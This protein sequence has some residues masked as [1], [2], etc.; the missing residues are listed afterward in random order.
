MTH[1]AELSGRNFPDPKNGG[2]GD[3]LNNLWNIVLL[4]L[5]G[6]G[7]VYKGSGGSRKETHGTNF[8]E[9]RM[10]WATGARFKFF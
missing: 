3:R 2:A 4:W 8:K 6:E 9:S 7:Y 10:S 1:G 5:K